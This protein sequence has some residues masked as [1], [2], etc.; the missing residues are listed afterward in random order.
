[1]LIL[2]KQTIEV[3]DHLNMSEELC[4]SFMYSDLRDNLISVRKGVYVHKT[5]RVEHLAIFGTIRDFGCY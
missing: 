5:E 3:F 1:M 4:T 2:S